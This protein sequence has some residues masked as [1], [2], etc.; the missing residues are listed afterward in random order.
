MLRLAGFVVEEVWG[1]FDGRTL[2]SDGSEHLILLARKPITDTHG[3]ASRGIHSHC[4]N[5]RIALHHA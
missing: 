1:D 2:R 4:R 3:A 5:P